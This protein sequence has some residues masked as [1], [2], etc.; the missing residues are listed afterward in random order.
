MVLVMFGGQVAGSIPYVIV[1]VYLCIVVFVI[2]F[3]NYVDH[4]F[5]QVTGCRPRVIVGR[6]AATLDDKSHQVSI[7]CTTVFVFVSP[8]LSVFVFVFVF[9]IFIEYFY[10]TSFYNPTTTVFHHICFCTFHGI[11]SR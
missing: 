6:G 1:F 11:C 10:C 5:R 4:V 7:C 3:S 8:S 2:V 9:V